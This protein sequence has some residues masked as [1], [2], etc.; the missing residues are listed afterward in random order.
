MVANA[1]S[2]SWTSWRLAFSKMTSSSESASF[3]FIDICFS[4]FGESTRAKRQKAP[5]ANDGPG[6]EAARAKEPPNL[7]GVF[8]HGHAPG[9]GRYLF[10]VQGKRRWQSEPWR[11]PQTSS[12]HKLPVSHK[13]HLPRCPSTFTRPARHASPQLLLRLSFQSPRYTTRDPLRHMGL[14]N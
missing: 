14:C 2:C 9:R 10:Q 8:A 13:G 7:A 6:Q 5:T 12:S 11:T 1:S 3:D 4:A